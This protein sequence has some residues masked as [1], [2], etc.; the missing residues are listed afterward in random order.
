MSPAL[1]L[2]SRL[3]AFQMSPLSQSLHSVSTQQYYL[4][5]IEIW[6]GRVYS[7]SVLITHRWIHWGG[8]VEHNIETNHDGT[9]DNI[10]RV[11]RAEN[12]SL[13][14]GWGLNF[15]HLPSEHYA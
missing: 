13:R 2:H 6:V 4:E 15:R 9:F 14:V 10:G 11:L 5:L 1:S 7:S 8:I 12:L 3:P